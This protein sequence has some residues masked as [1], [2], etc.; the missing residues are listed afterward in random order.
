MAWRINKWQPG[1]WRSRPTGH[2]PIFSDHEL[3]E[4]VLDKLAVLPPLVLPEKVEE[5]KDQLRRASRG[6]ALVLHGGDCAESFDECSGG[7]LAKQVKVLSQMGAL[8]TG[9]LRKPTVKIGRI[10]GQYAKPR[11]RPLEEVGG[12][13]VPVFLGDSINGFDTNDR[14]PNPLRLLM[15][16]FHASVAANYLNGEGK[17]AL[18]KNHRLGHW[19]RRCMHH[20]R[21]VQESFLAEVIDNFE[22]QQFKGGPPLGSDDLFTSHEALVLAA[23]EQQT[24]Y[25]AKYD[26][27]YN[28]SA[29]MLWIGERTR[30]LTGGHVEYCRGLANPI[31]IKVGPEASYSDIVALVRRI[32]PRNLEGKVVLITRFG[33]D[34]TARL[35]PLIQAVQ[36]AQLKVLWLSDPMHGN[37]SVL[38]NGLK[39]RSLKDITAEIGA[40]HAAHQ[41]VGRF[42]NG[43]HLELAG[44]SVTECIGG[45]GELTVEQLGQNYR[46]KCDPRLNYSQALDVAMWFAELETHGWTGCSASRDLL[47]PQPRQKLS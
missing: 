47:W 24:R 28:L 29:H 3:L 31:G 13:S 11:S 42:L 1:S 5:L 30:S 12:R 16:Y 43:L 14:S 40:A 45:F 33:Y 25:V 8:W 9:L 34:R 46:T 19:D 2:Q 41:E 7:R 39:T 15:A 27:W 22:R 4:S 20:P 36:Y 23:E 18:A 44:E 35:R 17:S 38:A 26:A 10:A 32:N 37:T 6:E 21:L